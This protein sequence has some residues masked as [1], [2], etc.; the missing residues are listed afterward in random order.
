MTAPA[1][2]EPMPAWKRLNPFYFALAP[3]GVVFAV[4]AFAYGYMAFQAV[5]AGRAGA[6]RH[7]EHPLFTWLR[8]HGDSALVIELIVLAVL[9]VASIATD[10]W[11]DQDA[12]ERDKFERLSH[13]K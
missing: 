6:G 4:T 3:A 7:A 8:A 1:A 13:L 11:W 9:T 12:R 5:N 10:K 2:S